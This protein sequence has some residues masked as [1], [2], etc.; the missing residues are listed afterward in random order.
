MPSIYLHIDCQKAGLKNLEAWHGGLLPVEFDHYRVL[1]GGRWVDGQGA[2]GQ[3]WP[4]HS[5]CSLDNVRS[6]E[7]VF[8]LANLP[9]AV[10]LSEV[11]L[12]NGDEVVAPKHVQVAP[13]QVN[14]CHRD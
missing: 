14:R 4:R 1:V 10:V 11:Q 9:D 7:K 2:Y 6:S 8:E 5:S 3:Q 13:S 12:Q